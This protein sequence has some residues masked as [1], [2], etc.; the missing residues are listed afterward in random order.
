MYKIL[1]PLAVCDSP[2]ARWSHSHVIIISLYLCS[3]LASSSSATIS[4]I[5]FFI[6]IKLKP[7]VFDKQFS[8]AL[9]AFLMPCWVRRKSGLMVWALK[10]KKNYWYTFFLFNFWLLS[11]KLFVVSSLFIISHKLNIYVNKILTICSA[12]HYKSMNQ[13]YL[14]VI[15]F[16]SMFKCTLVISGFALSQYSWHWEWIFSQSCICI[17]ISTIVPS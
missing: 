11:W 6:S 17:L 5:I 1:T 15:I 14:P 16:E 13:V 7:V 4:S 3:L 10:N 12:L 9:L 2:A 8:I